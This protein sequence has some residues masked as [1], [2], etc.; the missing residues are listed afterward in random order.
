MSKVETITE[1]VMLS[2]PQMR[3]LT[4]TEDI[5]ADIAGQGGGKTNNIGQDVGRWVIDYPEVKGFIGANTYE[6]LS[7]STLSRV[8]AELESKY[9]LEEYDKK[10]NP[11][12]QY[13]VGIRPPRG[14]GWTMPLYKY[15][16]YNNIMTFWNGCTIF[17][18][19]LD[20]YK[21][22]EGKEFGWAHLDETKDTKKEAI[23]N[24]IIARLR[25]KGLWVAPNGSVIWQPKMAD[26]VALR[27]GLRGWCPLYIHTSP[28][29]GSSDWLIEFLEIGSY[30][31]EI[32]DV[33]M[34]TTKFYDKTIT[35]EEAG[36]KTTKRI[37]IYQ[38][39]WNEHNLRAG[40][41]ATRKSTLSLGEYMKMVLGYPFAKN[42]GEFYPGFDRLQVVKEIEYNKELPIFQ[43]WDFNVL[44]YVTLECAQI[45]YVTRYWDETTQKKYE[46]KREGTE[47]LEV[48]QIRFFTEYCN[49]PPENSTEQTCDHFSDDFGED[50]PEV[51]VYGDASGRSR[52]EGL[53]A[54]TQY[55]IIR[56]SLEQTVYLPENYLRVKKENISRLKRRDLMNRIFEGKLP[57]VELYIDPRCEQLIRDC[58]YVLQGKDGGKYK[59]KGKDKNGIEYEVI[60][61]TSDAMEYLVC[62]LCKDYLKDY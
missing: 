32:K 56:T 15:K 51:F 23:T 17:L 1:S 19:S 2:E 14:I 9:G 55:K 38:T 62:E 7:S 37:I 57:Q 11:Y 39:H 30:A 41:I 34:D 18:G 5:I 36:V 12:G 22:H 21:I 52:I 27:N 28:A 61:H 33:L 46:D 59:E 13:V 40:Y 4:A 25:Q 47:E 20:N 3:V 31:K 42:G 50:N 53:G 45:E 10:N 26:D 24:V 54:L 29:E 8:F 43:T 49:K 48:L 44:P 60:G 35:S 58:E 16:N 6:Q